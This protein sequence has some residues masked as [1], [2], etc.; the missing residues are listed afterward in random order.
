MSATIWIAIG[1]GVGVAA[2]LIGLRLRDRFVLRRS[3]NATSKPERA[4]PNPHPYA[5]VRIVPGL[6]ACDAVNAYVEERIL[7]REAPNL[8]VPGCDLKVCGCRYKYLS[9]RRSAGDRRSPVPSF[10]QAW[11]PAMAD[12]KR[13]SKDRRRAKNHSGPRA[14]FNDHDA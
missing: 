11:Q 6:L 7:A 8:P 5:A 13:V 4:R 9:D 12:E 1:T 3:R 2:P 14:Y 10:S